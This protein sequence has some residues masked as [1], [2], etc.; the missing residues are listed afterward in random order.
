MTQKAH[1]IDISKHQNTFLPAAAK[2]AG[3]TAVILRAAYGN[4]LDARFQRFAADC[5][6]VAIST[7]ILCNDIIM[8]IIKLLLHIRIYFN[9]KN[10]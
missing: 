2:A 5:K 10:I 7:I 9:K 6:V 3:V 8:F 4:F 1:G